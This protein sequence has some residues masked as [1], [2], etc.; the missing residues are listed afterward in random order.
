MFLTLL[1]GTCL[2]GKLDIPSPEVLSLAW[3][4]RVSILSRYLVAVS[5]PES[6]LGAGGTAALVEPNSDLLNQ[7]LQGR[8]LGT[9]FKEAP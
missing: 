7:D 3:G 2:N 9:G 4:P 6:I 1:P 8:G 5:G